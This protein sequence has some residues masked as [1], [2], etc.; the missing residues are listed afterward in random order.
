MGVAIMIPL[1]FGWDPVQAFALLL[2]LYGGS[3][4]GGSITAILMK[5]PGT[6]SAAMTILDGYPMSQRGE[7]GKAIGLATISSFIGALSSTIIL[8]LSAPLIAE[9]ALKFGPHEYFALAFLGLTMIAYVSPGSMAKG[10]IAGMVGLL[11]STI[12]LEPALGHPR[13][14]FGNPNLLS[15][16]ALIPVLLGV[17]GFAEVLLSIEVRKRRLGKTAKLGKIMPSFSEIKA[18]T[19]TFFRGGLIGVLVGA[20]PAVGGATAIIIAY[21]TEK[22]LSKHPEKFG[23]GIA[24]GVCVVETANNASVGGSLIPLLSLGIPGDAVTAVLIGAFLI[25]GLTPGPLLFQERMEIASSIFILNL[26]TSLMLIP[27]GLLIVRVFSRIASL[28]SDILYPFIL[29]LC[30]VGTYSVRNS[31]FDVGVLIVFGIIGYLMGKV[32]IP[33]APLILGFVLGPLLERNLTRALIISSGDV[34]SF[35][36]RPI[37]AIM[38]VLTIVILIFPYFG[39]VF[40]KGNFKVISK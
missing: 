13:F 16:L 28:S 39:G 15:G 8:A 35:F 11:I 3:V 7:A 14:I 19:P 5:I 6:P 32:K 12:G 36:L 38:L 20:I 4:Y 34:A 40:R 31:F 9:L 1:T 26:F 29:L 23:T 17:F 21:G 25:H 27:F 24:E 18:L 33:A 10:L 2:G 22:R 37:S 30:V